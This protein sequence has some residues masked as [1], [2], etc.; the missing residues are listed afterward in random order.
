MKHVVRLGIMHAL[1][2]RIYKCL[3]KMITISFN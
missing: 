2:K 1:T 3:E